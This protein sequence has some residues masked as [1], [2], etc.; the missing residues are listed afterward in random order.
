M[1]MSGKP[2]QAM[3]SIVISVFCD[4]EALKIVRLFSGF[5]F[6]MTRFG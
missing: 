2:I 1:N 4:D 6:D 3:M 5:G